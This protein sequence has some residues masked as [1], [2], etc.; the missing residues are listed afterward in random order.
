MRPGTPKR[1]ILNGHANPP[2][3]HLRLFVAG[4][5][6]NSATARASLSEICSSYLEQ[7]CRVEIIDV[8]KDCRPALEESVFVTPALVIVEP[9]P[10]KVLFGNLTDTEKVLAALNL[11]T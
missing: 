9:G 10:R 11:A 5:E 6:P 4:D 8:L 1:S 2:K 7:G 3:Y